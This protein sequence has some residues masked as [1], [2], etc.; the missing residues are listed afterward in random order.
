MKKIKVLLIALILVLGG[1]FF[2]STYAT[3]LDLKADLRRPFNSLDPKAK[4]Q[5]TVGDNLKYTIVKIHNALKSAEQ[6]KAMYCLRGGKGFGTNEESDISQ[7]PVPYTELG[8]MHTNAQSVIDK[9]NSNDL[10]G[11]NLDRQENFIIN[12]YDNTQK[13][14]SVNIY[15]AI[16]WVLDESYLPIDNDTY[17]EADYKEEL[18]NKAGID[19]TD[20]SDVNKINKD[21]IEVI[22]QLAVWYFTNY[23]QQTAQES[24]TVSQKT[25]FPAQFLSINGNNNIYST[26]KENNLNK[27]YQYLIY[28]A[29]ENASSY[30]INPTTKARTK[31]IEAN[32]FDKTTPLTISEK[33]EEGLYS[34]YEIGPVKLLENGT[35][36]V[37]TTD[38]VLYDADGKVIPNYYIIPEI[39]QVT[40]KKE[41][42]SKID[43]YEFFDDENH[44]VTEL[45]KG[46]N[47]KIRFY[48]IFESGSTI[49]T[50]PGL[51]DLPKFNISK[52]KLELSSSYNL[53]T[54]KFLYAKENSSDNQA[55]VELDKQKVS[56]TDEIETATFDLSLRK[57]ITSIK[58]NE[59]EQMTDE[60]KENRV[61]KIDLSKLNTTE[62]D[63]LITTATYDHAKNPLP[64]EKNDTVIYTL[65]IY[66][67]G[68]IT[69]RALKV[70]DYLPEGLALKENSSINSTNGWT[71]PSEDGKTIV[72]EALN[73]TDIKAYDPEKKSKEG[74][75]KWQQDKSGGNSTGLYYAELQVECVVTADVG[76]NDKAL[77]N[78]AEIT[79][80]NINDRDSTPNNVDRSNYNPP[81]DNSSYQQ[82]DDDYE[83]LVLKAKTF[84]LALRKTIVGLTDK[85]QQ[86]KEISNA[87]VI[88]ID[89]NPLSDGGTTA[90][91]KHRKDPV[92]VETGDTVTYRFTVYNEGDIDGKVTSI[93]DYFPTGLEFD[94]SINT[95]ETYNFNVEGNKLTITPKT[96]DKLFEVEKYTGTG[97]EE[98]TSKSKHIDVK[99]KVTAQESN[100]D[101]ILT[102]VATMV[103]GPVNGD[104][105]DRDSN[106][107]GI[108]FNV[109]T[110]QDLNSNTLPGYKGNTE[111]KDELNDSTY[112]YK[113]QQDDDDFEKVVIK[114]K[115]F[116]LALRKTIVGLTDKDQQ[117][118]EISNARVIDIDVNPLSD[119]GTTADYKHRKDPVKVETGDTVTYRFTV[120]N[121]G[122]IDGKVTSIEDYFPTGL[123]FDPS[124]NTS[125]TY[126]FNVEGN[127]LTITPKTGDK[128][129]EV[130]KYTG[131]GKE[132]LTSKSKHIDVKFKVT[133][134]ESNEDQILTNVATMVYGPVNGD[135]KDRDSN[136]TGIEFNVPTAQDLNSNTLPG[137]KGNTENKDEL[138][139]STYHYKG[140]QDDDDFEK[141]VIKGKPFD[142]ALRKYISSIKRNG[143]EV[144]FDDR[145]P[146]INLTTLDEGTFDR[147]G[148]NEYTATYEHFKEPLVVKKGD[149]VTYT[150]RVYNEGSRD[151][152]A[153]EITDYLP[154]GLAFINN[155]NENSDWSIEKSDTNKI[156]PVDEAEAMALKEKANLGD[157]ELVTGEVIISTRA[158]DKKD[159]D[160]SNLIKAYDP[161]KTSKVGD[162]N[163]QQDELSQSNSGL[164]YREVQITCMVVAENTCRD[165]LTNI[166][167]ISEYKDKYG[168]IL[169]NVGDDRDSLANNVNISTYNNESQQDDDDFE[170]VVLTYF[171]LALRKFITGVDTNGNIE[172]INSRIPVVT[173][174]E[175][176]EGNLFKYTHPKGE[177]PVQV[178]NNDIV[179]YTLRVYNEGTLA[180]YAEEI[181]DDIPEGLEYLP[182]HAINKEYGWVMKDDKGDNTDK[183]E[184]A[185]SIATDYLSRENG[186]AKKGDS[187]INHNEIRPYYREN[188]ISATEPLNPDIET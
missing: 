127:K 77:R 66:N 68:E 160:D 14:I 91:Y 166:A 181:S 46:E 165:T 71:N 55:V 180:G 187:D 110:A 135:I 139:D 106:K 156:H 59:N 32:K 5:Y 182:D 118:K 10:Y 72:T 188:N 88:D 113:G 146:K 124:I 69:G 79:E 161:S 64:I 78:I 86:G 147:R 163:W 136:K 41:F 3:D 117:G 51:A 8:E 174:N 119:G 57:F 179:I 17:I 53:S 178:A 60:Q 128:L 169:P 26:V 123:E 131:T 84:D 37:N 85:D 58:R 102:N 65:R 126:N 150:L 44:E 134:Q 112:H 21:D 61:P 76:E 172:E 48:S 43:I 101:Q 149:I 7:D 164:Y 87:R 122:D 6:A 155:Y 36:K 138:N 22:Q 40:G 99:F 23:D 52:V 103:Y 33:I 186:N 2:S 105:K 93:E 144:S 152:Y 104:I 116:D 167:E 11:K 157:V 49:A 15:N 54:A 115:S 173:L 159:N 63:K 67:E 70:T 141:L 111:N 82:D 96:G 13:T 89:V 94:P 90:D 16:L 154:E 114:G 92:K 47:Y 25:M 177:L 140:Q 95:S 162:E 133:A 148:T 176:K 158:L 151:G 80:A 73:E 62:N 28:G 97:K 185:V 50:M 170:P 29:I 183:V 100:E 81:E 83:D 38:I 24:P 107:T 30:D 108:E 20:L 74:D 132:E 130:E 27:L 129:F 18:L 42:K 12:Y 9:Y 142:L 175:D 137:Y 120:Y 39:N 34:Y 31:I 4:Y 145:T 19:E 75:E 1:A 168:N 56:G 184:K 45:E 125:E 121:E 98:L 171:D 153:S 143:Q 109:P 35:G